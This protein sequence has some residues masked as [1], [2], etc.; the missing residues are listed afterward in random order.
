MPSL[1]YPA[2]LKPVFRFKHACLPIP[3]HNPAC[4]NSNF[5][6]KHASPPVSSYNQACLKSVFRFKHTFPPVPKHKQACLKPLSSFKHA[7]PLSGKKNYITRRINFKQK[8]AGSYLL[9]TF[10]SLTTDILLCFASQK[11]RRVVESG[12]ASL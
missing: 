1:P 3:R 5:L 4:L 11:S 7:G 6:F 10:A 12:Y 9:S 2:C 8:K